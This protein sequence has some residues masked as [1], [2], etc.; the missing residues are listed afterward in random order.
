MCT[1][2]CTA[3]STHSALPLI[4]ARH[5]AH[6]FTLLELLFF[7]LIVGIAVAGVTQIYVVSAAASGDPLVRKQAL[8]I[9]EGILE[10]VL[11]QPFTAPSSA[12][13]GTNRTYF[14]HVSAYDGYVA[15]GIS[16]VDGTAVTALSGY[17][18]AVAVVHPSSS[19]GTVATSDTW[20]ITVTV[21]DSAGA[22]TILTG[23]R[24][25]YG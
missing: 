24:F 11:L 3:R 23:Y 12:Y 8:S 21:T 18:V 1:E 16:T 20:V 5:R 19:I 2:L 9:A 6:G 17:T 25:N 13:S 14:D 15:H 7:I 4:T 10:E 22:Q